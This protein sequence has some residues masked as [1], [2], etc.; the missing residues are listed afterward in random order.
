MVITPVFIRSSLRGFLVNALA[1]IAAALTGGCGPSGSLSNMWHDPSFQ[2][3]PM[4]NIFIIAIRKDPVRRRLW[5][6]GFVTELEKHG[7][8]ATPS[9]RLFPDA[10][11]DTA[12]S[13]GAIRSQ[14]FDGVLVTRRLGVDTVTKYFPGYTKD[15]VITRYNNWT[16]SYFTY[17]HTEEVPGFTES[18]LT[19]RH[20]VNVWSTKEGGGLVWSGTGEIVDPASGQSI[21]HEIAE[22]IVPE[23]ANQGVIPPER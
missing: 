22:L 14:H 21:N 6:D 10:V 13:I 12:Q 4:K 9:Y 3:G 1:C 16:N 7:V 8:T 19:S 17:Y 18:E 15:T 11:P 5:E 23:L 2:S 20:Q